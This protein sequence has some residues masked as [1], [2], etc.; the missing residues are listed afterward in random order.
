MFSFIKFSTVHV[1]RKQS[2]IIQLIILGFLPYGVFVMGLYIFLFKYLK[3]FYWLFF[4][5][6]LCVPGL[7]ISSSSSFYKT[8]KF[9]CQIIIG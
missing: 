8:H 6:K 1:S 3:E 9:Q 7:A 2:T 5:H 4:I